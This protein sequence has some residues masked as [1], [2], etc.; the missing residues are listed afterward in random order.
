MEPW[1]VA[2]LFAFVIVV[3]LVLWC[4]AVMRIE[5]LERRLELLEIRRKAKGE[6][7][8]ELT[9]LRDKIYELIARDRGDIEEEE[10]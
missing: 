9:A 1:G 2:T 7:V 6:R 10:L 3:G 4:F 5:Q 8:D